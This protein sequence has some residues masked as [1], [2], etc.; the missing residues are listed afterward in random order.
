MNGGISG[1]VQNDSS[2]RLSL[3]LAAATTLVAG[4]Y[5][6]SA[7][8]RGW[9]PHDEGALAQSA[10]R[11][12]HGAVPHRDFGELYTGLLSYLNALA[13]MVFGP[14]LFSLRLMLFVWFLVWVVVLLYCVSH[15]VKPGEAFLITLAAV[16]W[17]P[18]NYPAAIPSWYNLFCATAGV[19]ALLRYLRTR[20]TKWL[21]VAG[22]AGGRILS[23]QV[24]GPLLHRSGPSF[25]SLPR[26]ERCQPDPR[27]SDAFGTGTI[28]GRGRLRRYCC[29]HRSTHWPTGRRERVRSLRFANCGG[30]SGRPPSRAR[31]ANGGRRTLPAARRALGGLWGRRG[32]PRRALPPSVSGDWCTWCALAWGCRGAPT[33]AGER[34]DVSSTPR[35]HGAKCCAPGLLRLASAVPSSG[36]AIRGV[37]TRSSVGARSPRRQ[38]ST[39]IHSGLAG[40]LLALPRS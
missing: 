17:G 12:L 40:V 22:F 7:L 39:D 37:G 4:L 36:T 27:P 5:M 31:C 3:P 26:T 15:F 21:M 6:W 23:V 25:P 35:L 9:V 11:V 16:A 30:V 13:F 14:N 10:W 32:A 28:I 29:D 8:R 33:A 1:E 34:R 38:R 20:S 19:A 24:H 2:P 18:P